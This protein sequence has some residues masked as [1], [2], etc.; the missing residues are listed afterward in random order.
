MHPYRAVTDESGWAEMRVAKGQYRLLVS[1]SKYLARSLAFEVM[2]DVRT[3]A[4]L[5]LAPATDPNDMYY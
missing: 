5:D 1:Q 3:T 4:E 2:G